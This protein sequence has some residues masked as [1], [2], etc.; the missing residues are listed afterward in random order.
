[1][2]ARNIKPGFFINEQLA[3]C[4]FAAR[5][6]FE[7]LWCLADRE[8]R[9]EDKPK[10]IKIQILPYDDVD[11]D[12]LLSEL[13]DKDLIVRYVVNG[14]NYIEIPTFKKHQNPHMKE[15][16][17][18]I[19]PSNSPCSNGEEI[20]EESKS[21]VQAPDKHSTSTVLALDNNSSDPAESGILNPE[22]GFLNAEAGLPESGE[23][24]KTEKSRSYGGEQR[25]LALPDDL[26]PEESSVI[27]L[28][29]GVEGL[30]VNSSGLIRQL[31]ALRQEFPS[32]D[33]LAES[34]KMALWQEGR[35]VSQRKKANLAL[36]MRKWV[37]RA[38][39]NPSPPLSSFE[40]RNN[41]P[42]VLHNSDGSFGSLTP[43]EEAVQKELE[44][45]FGDDLGGDG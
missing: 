21:T 8:G 10:K 24:P 20:I 44:R 26:T 32:V 31:R 35:S 18:V 41:A 9:L 36:F 7:G 38:A 39:A 17:S 40:R 13:Q 33:C 5:I 34:K 43:E 16:K 11:A 3:E 15:P 6:L 29:Q 37:E 30:Q 25:A 22:S 45:R 14:C 1:M 12:E 27:G 2:R 42:P 23:K 19:P 28:F 4:C